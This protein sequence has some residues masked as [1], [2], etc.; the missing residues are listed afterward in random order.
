M[1]NKILIANRGEIACRIAK[2]ARKLGIRT[3]GVFSEADK[4]SRHTQM[5]DEAYMIG[6]PQ[7]SLSYLKVDHI[8]DVAHRTGAQAIHPGYGFLSENA[9]FVHELNA[10]NIEF[11]GP[12]ASAIDKMGSKSESKAI[13]DA[14]N[15][16]IVRGYHGDNQDPDFL[17]QEAHKIGFPVMLKASLGGGGK[18]MR[19]VMN[20]SEFFDQLEAAK[21]EGMKSFS[22]DHM[23]IEK[24]IEKPRHIEVQVF[25]DKLGNYVHLNER[26]CSVQ[27]RHQKVVEEAPSHLDESLRAGIGEAA[28]MAAQAVGYYNAG[29]VEFIFDTTTD[30]YYF[31][32]MNTRL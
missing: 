19:I 12:P 13:M 27:R 2:T 18:G 3:V 22:D 31:M 20:E 21:R 10:N 25:G 23:L 16:P 11:I 4:G 8:M 24:Y 17:L 29:T 26:D 28:V 15:V 30:K 32:E 7:P 1:F 14:A 5:M 6:P 9:A